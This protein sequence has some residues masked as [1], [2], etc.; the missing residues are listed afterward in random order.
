MPP[1][2]AASHTLGRLRTLLL[3][4]VVVSA[5]GLVLELILLEHWEEWRQW[6]PLTLLALSA[7]SAATLLWRPGPGLLRAFRSVMVLALLSGVLGSVFHYQSNAELE[8]EIHPELSGVPLV[9]ASLGGG[10]P[11]LAP[12]AMIQLALLGLLA[13]YRH[14]ARRRT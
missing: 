5:S 11:T 2:D 13:V 8:R 1:E 3:G 10:T 9:R 7:V 4:L 12:G 6:V 14:P